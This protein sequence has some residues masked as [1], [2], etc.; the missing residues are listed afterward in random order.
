MRSA[1]RG[2]GLAWPSASTIVTWMRRMTTAGCAAAWRMSAA[3][4]RPARKTITSCTSFLA[5]LGVRLDEVR[6]VVRRLRIHAPLEIEELD[7]PE[8]RR[9]GFRLDRDVARR[10]RRAV[11]LHGRID[12]PGRAAAHLRLRVLDHGNA[13]DDV[14][15]Q[16][17]A[18]HGRL[19]AHPLVAVRR[20]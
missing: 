19:H 2:T 13:I 5:H 17:V 10:H 6:L 9:G 4:T 12:R 3:A 16:L 8:V 15:D 20:P 11:D 7:L 1:C 18:A 14:S